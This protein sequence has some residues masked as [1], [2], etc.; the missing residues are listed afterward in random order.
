MNV[1]V[2]GGTGTLGRH[3]VMLLRQS[4]HRARILSREPR[5]HVDAVQGDLRTGAGLTKALAG[6]EV[7]VHAASA[8]REPLRGRSVDVRGTRR[9]LQLAQAAGIRHIVHMSIVGI[10]GVSYPYFKTK[11]AS[12]AVVRKGNVPWSIV[13]ATQFHD[14]FEVIL[15]GF[16]RV[17]GIL[18]VPFGWQVQPVEAG[19]VARRVVDIALGQ[20]AETLTDF[21]G[22]EIRDLKSIAESWLRARGENRRLIN[23][24]M[25]FK[26]SRQF[27]AGRITCPDHKEGLITFDQYLAEKYALS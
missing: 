16:S 14:L 13:R 26:F 9:L 6:M 25:P 12:E 2:T 4:G 24:R 22:P 1:L 19:E 27:T 10:D 15:R 21:G 23:L 11:L 18:A 8:T 20:P 7:I 17:P 5:G 3:V